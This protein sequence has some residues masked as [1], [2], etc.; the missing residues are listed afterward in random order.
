M[1]P[2]LISQSVYSSPYKSDL[3][4]KYNGIANPF[5][6]ESG[7]ILIIPSEDSMSAQF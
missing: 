3:Y 7:E 6:I 5:S 1:R 2:D 4:L